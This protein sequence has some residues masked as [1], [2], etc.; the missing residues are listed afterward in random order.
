MKDFHGH[1]CYKSALVVDDH[2]DSCRLICVTLN[3]LGIG[4][5]VVAKDGLAGVEAYERAEIKPDLVVCDLYMPD[6][7]GIEFVNALGVRDYVGALVMC[8]AGDPCILD[9][10][11]EVATKV[12]GLDMVGAFLKPIGVGA[13]DKVLNLPFPRVPSYSTR[14]V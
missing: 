6:M 1:R 8:T 11:Y 7:D 14:T 9:M 5:V 10:A 12:H 13:F 2:P 4:N 3:I